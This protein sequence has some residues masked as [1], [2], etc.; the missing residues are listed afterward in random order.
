MRPRGELSQALVK[1]AE[2][3]PGAV[4]TLAERAQVGYGA[5]RYTASRMVDRGELVV[6][7]AGRPAL[8]GVPSA[9]PEGQ[10]ATQESVDHYLQFLERSFWERPA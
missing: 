9:L 6:L 4:R 10:G 2:Q 3:G 1:A 8:L 5:A 7:G